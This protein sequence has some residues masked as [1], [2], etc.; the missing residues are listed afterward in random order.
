[1]R[2]FLYNKYNSYNFYY[3]S[4]RNRR[5][6]GILVN[7]KLDYRI[8]NTFSDVN[9]NILGIKMTINGTLL[10]CI[11]VYGPNSNDRLFFND[12]DNL[13]NTDPGIPTVMGETGT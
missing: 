12:I 9:E 2:S 11:A 13:L 8:E 10:R 4:T 6:V 1:V 3:N 5:G 7:K